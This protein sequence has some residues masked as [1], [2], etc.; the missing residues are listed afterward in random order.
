MVLL[1]LGFMAKTV[2]QIAQ[3]L[4]LRCEHVP[5]FVQDFMDVQTQLLIESVDFTPL[6]R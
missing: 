1:W 3:Q 5:E 2:Q 6:S 4:A